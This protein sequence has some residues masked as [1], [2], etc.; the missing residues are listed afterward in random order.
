MLFH[1]FRLYCSSIHP[2]RLG[3]WHS[4]GQKMVPIELTTQLRQF[5]FYIYPS[6]C[7]NSLSENENFMNKHL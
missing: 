7:Y 5:F 4:G 3:C 6:Y 2:L 1:T